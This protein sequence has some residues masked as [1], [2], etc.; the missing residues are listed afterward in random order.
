L[1]LSRNALRV[2]RVPSR[3]GESL[4]VAVCYQWQILTREYGRGRERGQ[5]MDKCDKC[6]NK[7]TIL[8]EG[9]LYA[10]RLCSNHAAKLCQALGGTPSEVTTMRE[11]AS[12]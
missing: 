11:Y 3:I 6:E 9:Y 12:K 1:A 10:R 7:A 2:D 8:I 4:C 5:V